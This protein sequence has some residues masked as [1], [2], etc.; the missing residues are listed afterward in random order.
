MGLALTAMAS[1][2]QLISKWFFG[3]VD[4]L[5]KTNENKSTWGIIVVKSNLFVRF[6]EET[7][8]WKKYFDFVWPL[9]KMSA[10]LLSNAPKNLR[11]KMRKRGDVFQCNAS[12]SCVILIHNTF[13]SIL[14]QVIVLKESKPT[15]S[16]LVLNGL[17]NTRPSSSSLRNTYDIMGGVGIWKGV[18][19][20]CWIPILYSNMI[21]KRFLTFQQE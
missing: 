1:K 9:W 17:N 18:R 10:C 11:S 4:F 19:I 14:K 12:Y 8:V 15:S 5:Q 7:S 3:V 20:S 2:G 6:S 21:W 16:A 13:D